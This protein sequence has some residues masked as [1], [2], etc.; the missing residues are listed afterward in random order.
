MASWC[1]RHQVETPGL[2]NGWAPPASAAT[3]AGSA[4]LVLLLPASREFIIFAV[5]IGCCLG[6]PL[7]GGRWPG[8]HAAMAGERVMPVYACFPVGYWELSRLM[9]KVNAVRFA[10]WLPLIVVAGAAFGFPAWNNGVAVA[11]ALA[12]IVMVLQP[13]MIA[14]HFAYV[15]DFTKTV[16]WQKLL[17]LGTA[18]VQVLGAIVGGGILFVA[19]GFLSRLIALALLAALSLFFWVIYGLLQE[20]GRVDLLAAPRDVSLG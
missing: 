19:P 14:G 16:N 5:A 18:M 20:R 8:F 12:M 10:A 9:F 2:A 7:L 3:I 4:L 11:L 13:F 17:V 6:V 15:S 1:V